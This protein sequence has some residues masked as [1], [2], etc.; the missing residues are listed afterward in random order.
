MEL[1]EDV[2]TAEI[3]QSQRKREYLKRG[4]N[5]ITTKLGET[6]SKIT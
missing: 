1:V 6:S 4:L 3:K 5:T 2:M